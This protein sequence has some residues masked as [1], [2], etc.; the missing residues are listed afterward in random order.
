MKGPLYLLLACMALFALFYWGFDRVPQDIKQAEKSRSLNFETFDIQGLVQ[1]SL[2]ALP[3][4]TRSYA[5]SAQAAIKAEKDTLRAISMMKDLSGFW[6][7]QGVRGLAA[8][9][10]EEIAKV[11]D[12]AASWSIAGTSYVLCAQV[13]DSELGEHCRDQAARAFENAISIEPE[14]VDHRI[15]LALSYVYKPLEAQPMKG[16][17]MLVDLNK[18]YPDNV[19]V[20]VQL[21]RLAIQTSQW[22]KAEERLGQAIIL[23]P[24]NLKAT[25]MLPEVYAALGKT[26]LMEEYK[27]KCKS[28]SEELK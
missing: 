1:E 3:P 22:E 6:Y 10:A 27:L 24:K 8:H 11:Q 17:L 16:I 7:Q 13:E 12:D 14:N 28:F 25:C 26:E 4:E 20:L 2:Q 9:Y 15:N 18:Q 19:P 21:A 23:E 5:I